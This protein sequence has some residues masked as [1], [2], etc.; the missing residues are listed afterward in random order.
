[1]TSLANLSQCYPL[2]CKQNGRLWVMKG[3][4][5]E[6]EL[7]QLPEYCQLQQVHSVVVPYLNEQQRHLVELSFKS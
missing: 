6:S 7:Q 2:I 3:K 1:M 4:Y 5:P